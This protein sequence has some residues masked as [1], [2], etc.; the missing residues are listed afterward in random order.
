MLLPPQVLPFLSHDDSILREQAVQYF[1]HAHD[2]GPLTADVCWA[3]IHTIGLGRGAVGLIRL[4]SNLPQSDATTAHL[5]AAL[6]LPPD[7]S[8]REW[9][10]EALEDL[11]IDQLRR[12]ADAILARTDLPTDTL[13]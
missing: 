8:M 7:E 5:L 10:I 6:D 13:D 11:E 4:L 9:L 3:A 1:E 2:P 12:H